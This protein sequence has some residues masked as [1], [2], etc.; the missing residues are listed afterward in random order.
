MKY[1]IRKCVKPGFC[2]D[3]TDTQCVH[4]G[5]IRAD[6]P[7][8]HCDNEVWEDCTGCEFIKE[9]YRLRGEEE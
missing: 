4:S 2:K 5:V 1:A 9:Y 6:C 8:Y 7:K 3:C